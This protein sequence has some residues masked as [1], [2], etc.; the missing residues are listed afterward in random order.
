M[1]PDQ[2]FELFYKDL[3][4]DMHPYFVPKTERWHWWRDLFMNAF[5]GIKEPL[6]RMSWAEAP[7]MWL[8]GY[9][10]YEKGR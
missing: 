10:H 1:N 4:E 3:T 2:L 6:S 5:Q 9:R 8:A 7:R